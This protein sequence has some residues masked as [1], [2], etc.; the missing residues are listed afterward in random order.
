MSTALTVASVKSYVRLMLGLPVVSVEL[1][2]EQLEAIANEAL[3]NYSDVKP[4]FKY[5][6]VN[7]ATGQQMYTLTTYGR[8]IIE[9]FREDPLRMSVE[10]NEFDI[11][12]YNQFQALRTNP[13]DYYM[14]RLWR[15]EVKR[16][17]GAD[18]DW[19]FDP[20][21]GKLFISQ[22]PTTAANLVYVYTVDP[23]FTEVPGVDDDWIEH[24]SLAL[25]KIILGRIRNKYQGIPGAE[26]TITMDG[27]E[28]LAE[29]KEEKLALE[30]DLQTKTF[31]VPPIRG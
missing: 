25:A 16:A 3:K 27:A 18:D 6:F 2:D 10:L 21:T 30:A 12:R 13:G 4:I 15:D 9:V 17:V 19:D 1:N 11:F 14:T 20:Q 7:I 8:G 28:L 29:G 23:T 31:T 26:G 24:Y 22:P 5:G